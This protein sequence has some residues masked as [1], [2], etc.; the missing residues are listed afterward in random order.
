MT[1]ELLRPITRAWMGKLHKAAKHKKVEF[2]D[3]ADEVMQF[4]DGP[5]DF[6]YGSKYSES[7]DAAPQPTFR[8]TVNKVAEV[9]QLYGP[10]LYHR[11][12]YRQVN[13]RTFPEFPMD[14][15]GDPNNPQAQAA[16]QQLQSQDS[17]RQGRITAVA[18]LLQHMLNFTPNE[19]DLRGHSRQMV[20]EAV[21][22]GMSLLWTEV[23]QP[24]GGNARYIGS[25]YDSID[26]LLMDPDVEGIEHA[27]WFARRRVLPVWE[28]EDRY[29]LPRETLRGNLQS[30]NVQGEIEASDEY[31]YFQARGDTNDLFTYFE[32]YSR[33]G[34]G[35]M[36][37]DC[38]NISANKALLDQFGKHIY[39]AVCD[40]YPYPLNLPEK[41]F[42]EADLEE[43]FMRLQW[44][45]PFWADPTS[46]LPFSYTAFHKRP[47]KLWPM[48][49]IKPGLGELK[50][51]NWAISFLAD[52]I[53]NTS[54]DFIG[55][56]KSAGEDIKTSILSG[57]DLTL[58]EFDKIQGKI[59]DVVQTFQFQPVNP[60]LWKIIDAMFGL[61]DKRL[62]TNE[63]MYGQSSRQMRSAQEASVKSDQVNIRPDDM[64]EQVEATMTM[65]ARKEALA[66][67]WI[68]T[69]KDVLPALGP[70]RARLWDSLVRS[71]NLEDIVAELEYRIEA[72]SVRK[73]NKNRD[74]ENANTSVQ[75]WAP[76]FQNYAMQ[77]GD[78]NAINSLAEHWA[79]ANDMD[80]AKMRLEPPPPQPDQAQQQ[81]QQLDMQ[82]A[83]Q[84]LQ[85]KQ[86]A[87]QQTLQQAQEK[88]QLTLQQL[89]EKQQVTSMTE[90]QR[91]QQDLGQDD[92]THSQE[93]RQDQEVHVQ[94]IQQ[95]QENHLLKM[96]Q[97][98]QMGEVQ[99]DITKKAAAAKPAPKE[100]SNA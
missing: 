41:V 71:T 8:M 49:H 93:I 6:M 24:P 76:F 68:L 26:N 47:R 89:Q 39:M 28:V 23:Y 81:Q 56:L 62:G 45:I 20:D 27:K 11:N 91:A 4:F 40:E 9:V 12:P 55:V 63:L 37:K 3:D 61:L 50:F 35:H 13:P 16:A 17:N 51:I 86:Q 54:R 59:S 18:G 66:S 64:A 84:E 29:G 79:K 46:P 32:V 67:R 75:V 60:D 82:A 14:L 31:K 90:V 69:S 85:A 100:G 38:H 21:I 99:Q 92:Q 48:S 2:Q 36:L 78:F 7:E 33:M 94:D 52:K 42:Q 72:G 58:L 15:L 98:K 74:M 97:T 19:L 83:Q 25:F 73:P 57:K 1:E 96:L 70:E 80:P 87:H 34:M 88:H 10:S 5:H 44:P 77:S 65:V 43:V 53:K 30:D 95:S 22:K